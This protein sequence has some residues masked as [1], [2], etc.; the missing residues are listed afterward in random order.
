MLPAY[1]VPGI[2]AEFV[3]NFTTG[4]MVPSTHIVLTVQMRKKK[5]MNSKK[6]EV[7]HLIQQDWEQ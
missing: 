1:N 2:V 4:I 6:T 3:D 7:K 5:V